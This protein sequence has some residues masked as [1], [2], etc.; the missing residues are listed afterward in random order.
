[1]DTHLAARQRVR[2]WYDERLRDLAEFIV[3]PLEETWARHSF[4]MYTVL[5]TD[6]A[7]SKLSRDA[8]MAGLD[9]DGIETRPVF[10]PM[11]VL[12]PYLQ[13][14]RPFPVADRLAARG[15]NLPTHGMLTEDDVDYIVARI[16]SRIAASPAI[17]RRA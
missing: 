2:R 14:G 13:D 5:L 7:A 10:Y 4:W 15:L 12:P 9:E 16:R 3:P 11:H 8:F 1:V 17:G 6:V